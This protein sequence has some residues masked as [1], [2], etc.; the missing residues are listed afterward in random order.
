MLRDQATA[1]VHPKDLLHGLGEGP[2][3]SEESS[4]R[5]RKLMEAIGSG[6]S[7]DQLVLGLGSSPAEL[8][9]QLLALER[10]GELLCE[11]GLHWRKRRS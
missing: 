7:L 6:A 8:V 1:L 4:G 5:H 10:Q 3:R 11:S 2:L 9:P